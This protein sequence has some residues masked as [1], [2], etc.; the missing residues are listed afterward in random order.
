MSIVHLC[1]FGT[2]W[3]WIALEDLDLKNELIESLSKRSLA[4]H[5]FLSLV[6]LEEGSKMGCLFRTDSQLSGLEEEEEEEEA[7]VMAR[8]LQRP[9]C[10]HACV[11][12]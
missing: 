9:T 12:S 7:V 8:E 4:F 11:Q 2:P 6:L 1:P 3:S 5:K 10:R